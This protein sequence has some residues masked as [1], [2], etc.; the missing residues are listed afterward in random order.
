MVSGSTTSILSIAASS[1]L[2]NEPVMLRW[3]SSENLAASASSFSPSWNFTF[4]RSLIVTVL[5]SSEMSEESASC[6]M[7]FR[8]SSISNSL[9][10][11]DANTMRPT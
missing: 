2:R 11:I 9:S 6:G 4:G 1:G 5:P 8:F 3:R 10:Q 7:T